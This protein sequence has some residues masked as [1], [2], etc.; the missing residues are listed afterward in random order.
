MADIAPGTIAEKGAIVDIGA[1]VGWGDIG[2]GRSIGE[3]IGY[4]SRALLAP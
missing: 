2:P 4:L 3:K 1:I